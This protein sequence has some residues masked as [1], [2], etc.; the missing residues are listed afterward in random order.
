MRKAASG[1]NNWANASINKYLNGTYYNNLNSVAQSQIVSH[2]WSIGEV[3]DVNNDLAD[4]IND[5]NSSKWNG[6]IALPTLSEFIRTNSNTDCNTVSKYKNEQERVLAA[7]NTI[8]AA[9]EA[10]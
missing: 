2:D 8:H 7:Q 1:S 6:K 9:A 3:T 10:A 5:E 4:Q